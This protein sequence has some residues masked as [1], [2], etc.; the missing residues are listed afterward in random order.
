MSGAL[1]QEA[2]T[3]C[4]APRAMEME[5]ERLD[6]LPWE[7]YIFLEHDPDV[8]QANVGEMHGMRL[9]NLCLASQSGA[10][11][12]DTTSA[13]PVNHQITLQE[14]EAVVLLGGLFGQCFQVFFLIV[15]FR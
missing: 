1:T 5:D 14:A 8:G 4:Q 15:F 12:T 11:A 7:E 3:P 13:A 2:P 9:P 6:P 10:A